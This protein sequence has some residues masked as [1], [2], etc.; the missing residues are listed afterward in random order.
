VGHKLTFSL[1]QIRD[2]CKRFKKRIEEMTSTYEARDEWYP[3]YDDLKR[4]LPD[5]DLK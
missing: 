5:E 3:S 1:C 2:I 4:Y